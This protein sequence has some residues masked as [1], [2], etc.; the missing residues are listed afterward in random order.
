[1]F[2][3]AGAPAELP[4][5]A[6]GGGETDHE[7]SGGAQVR[8]PHRTDQVPRPQTAPHSQVALPRLPQDTHQVLTGT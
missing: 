1:M 7:Q 2:R 3:A 6:G 8:R 5:S 4:V